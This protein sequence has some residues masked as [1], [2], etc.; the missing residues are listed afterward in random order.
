M[1]RLPRIQP[2]LPG[3]EAAAGQGWE[4][5]PV[6]GQP[7][8]Y[9]E[10]PLPRPKGAAAPRPKRRLAGYGIYARMPDGLPYGT[11]YEESVGALCPTAPVAALA[12]V[13]QVPECYYIPL[14]DAHVSRRFACKS[15]L[16]EARRM[17]QRAWA[18]RCTMRL[19]CPT[20]A[21]PLTAAGAIDR[22]M[23]STGLCIYRIW[24]DATHIAE[25]QRELQMRFSLLGLRDVPVAEFYETQRETLAILVR[26]S[27]ARKA[28]HR[29][30]LE[31]DFREGEIIALPADF[32]IP[33]GVEG[34]AR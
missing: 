5:R 30:A 20:Q 17:V 7:G 28:A 6:P 25:T 34:G 27:N 11:R 32:D 4:L 19:R 15:A 9:T 23:Q 2:A 3:T 26:Q 18:L 8:C 14:T 22:L 33:M 16:G 1:K 31:C 21:A 12:R 13:A 24:E 10:V 29:R